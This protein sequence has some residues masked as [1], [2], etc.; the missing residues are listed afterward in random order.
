[1][2]LTKKVL[3]SF[4]C[5]LF[6]VLVQLKIIF[7]FSQ[8]SIKNVLPSET[9]LSE[10]QENRM[11]NAQDAGEKGKK[12]TGHQSRKRN[13]AMGAGDQKRLCVGLS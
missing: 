13:N 9:I 12:D 11:E 8:K 10:I 2:S 3:S 1:M 7:Y 4:I 5:I 6:S